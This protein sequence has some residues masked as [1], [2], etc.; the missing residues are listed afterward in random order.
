MSNN[1]AEPTT[2][3]SSTARVITLQVG[4]RRFITTHET[5]VAESGFF[6][7]LLSG[8]WDNNLMED[9]SYFIDADPNLFDHIL[10]YLRRGVFPLFYEKS[11]GHDYAQ[12]LALLEEARYFNI[13]QLE[14]WL[15]EQRYL[16]V[17]NTQYNAFVVSENE[18]HLFRIETWNK[19][20][21]YHPQWVTRKVYICP[22]NIACHRDNPYKCGKECRRVQGNDKVKFEKET[23]LKALLVEKKTE[24][25][26]SVLLGRR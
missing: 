18:G 25:N 15:E 6:A 5:L 3:S 13:G 22:R 20:F 16:D 24:C 10:C 12:Y 23:S 1:D 7:S 26:M 19:E 9:G 8:R 11:K 17:F 14:S 4:E 21:E 2:N